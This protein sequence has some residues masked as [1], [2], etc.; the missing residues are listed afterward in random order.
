MQKANEA[1][2]KALVNEKRAYEADIK[3][4]TEDTSTEPKT[5]ESGFRKK[6]REARKGVRTTLKLS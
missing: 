4:F 3:A 5:E 6:A 2:L 1:D